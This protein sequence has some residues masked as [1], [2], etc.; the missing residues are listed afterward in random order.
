MKKMYIN[1]K[2]LNE[3]EKENGKVSYKTLVKRYFNDMVL[4][5]NITKIFYNTINGEYIEP[6]LK[7]GTDYDKENDCYIDIY[8]YF[9]VDQSSWQYE[10]LKELIKQNNSN[11]IILYYID[12]LDMYI[13]GVPHLGIGWDYVLTDIEYTTN[14][15]GG[16]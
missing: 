3:Y 8:Q 15:N 14:I 2:N 9:I 6:E 10:E 12:C 16:I 5:N 7:I 4:C 11:D 13:L 1:E